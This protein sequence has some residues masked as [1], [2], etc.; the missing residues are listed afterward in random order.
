MP[1]TCIFWARLYNDLTDDT[2]ADH[3][4]VLLHLLLALLHVVLLVDLL[5][6]HLGRGGPG[7]G[8]EQEDID[9]DDAT[10]NT[11]DLVL[12]VDKEL[13]MEHDEDKLLTKRLAVG[14]VTKQLTFIKVESEIS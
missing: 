2:F 4:L 1:L 10:V 7:Y 5:L 13:D 9:R 12:E 8:L 3:Q 14:V 11:N 6:D